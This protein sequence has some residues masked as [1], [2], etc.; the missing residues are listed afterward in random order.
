[1]TEL[2]A[3]FPQPS[4]HR[5]HFL[6]KTKTLKLLFPQLLKTPRLQTSGMKR[7]FTV[8]DRGSD[9]IPLEWTPKGLGVTTDVNLEV[10]VFW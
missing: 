4:S 5:R 7:N 2:P 10:S 9:E 1:M 3:L 8:N 6:N